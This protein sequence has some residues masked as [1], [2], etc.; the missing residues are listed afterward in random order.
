MAVDQLFPKVIMK[1]FL[2]T[3]LKFLKRPSFLAFVYFAVL[4]IVMTYPLIFRMGAI[5][6]GGGGDG[7]YFVWLVRWYQKALFELKISPFFDPYLNYPKGWNLA[8]TDIT[9]A[10]VALALPGSLLFGPTWG[11]N[12]SMLLSFVLSG[13]GMYLWIRDLTKDNLAGLVAGMIYGFI[14]FHMAHF[15][16]GHLSLSGLQWF[17]FYFWGLYK[18]LEQDKFFWKP[19]LLASISIF[20]IGMTSP[21]YVYMTILMS[22][23]F[24]L[25]FVLFKGYK[26]LKDLAFWKSILVF[27]LFAT[28]LVGISMLPYLRLNAQGGLAT[29][30]VDYASRYSA[31]PTDFFIPSIHQFLWGD[32]VVKNFSYGM[33][34]ESTLYIGAVALV[35][36]II[37]CWKRRKLAHPGLLGIAVLVA[38]SAFIL[39]LG[40]NLHW[41]GK[42]I[43][44]LPRILQ[45]IFHRTKMPQFYLPAYYLFRYLPFF[46]KMRVL[47]RFGLFTLVFTS[48]MAGLGAYLLLNNHSST[49]RKWIAAGLLVLVFIDFYP[50]PIAD[51]KPIENDPASVWL[52]TQPDTGSVAVFPFISESDQGQV[53]DTLIYQKPFLGGY[54]NAN[55]PDQYTRI[56]PVMQGFPSLQ[57]VDLLKQLD[58]AYV[59]VYSVEY[60]D[61]PTVDQTIQS[62]GLR[63]LQVCNS[64]YV[65]G[66]P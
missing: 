36:A 29:R 49:T 13:W 33:S 38:L 30:S 40:I 5:V 14:P 59:V 66:F 50:G 47:M 6:G 41:L 56:G 31:S 22:G 19:I 7:T 11:Y 54:F 42:T 3:L 17:P 45:P 37:A 44:S 34:H 39:A 65:Y 64:E 55:Q 27:G 16:V 21:Y 4:T 26:R 1:P 46:S 53:Y 32:W 35:L 2:R 25:G 12:F 58:V 18:L 52:A 20:L 28:A 43:V 63:L 24:I 61:Y 15:I 9:P 51:I 60:S 48:L 23:V 62:L 10:M 8:S 57:S